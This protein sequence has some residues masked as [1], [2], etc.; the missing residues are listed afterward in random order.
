MLF[1][2]YFFSYDY[3]LTYEVRKHFYLFFI[4]LFFYFFLSYNANMNKIE[5]A[6]LQH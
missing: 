1:P 6:M 2:D 3:G 5:Y 4:F